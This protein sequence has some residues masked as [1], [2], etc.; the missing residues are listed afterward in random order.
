[1]LQI[2]P[3]GILCLILT[4]TLVSIPVVPSQAATTTVY[5]VVLD[6]SAQPQEVGDLERLPVLAGKTVVVVRESDHG[7]PVY[8]L[9]ASPFASFA[10]ARRVMRALAKRYPD[11]RA[12]RIRIDTG[13]VRR[14]DL[15][16]RKVTPALLASWLEK[17]RQAMIDGDLKSADAYFSRIIELAAGTKTARQ[18]R[19]WLGVVA[20]RRGQG[21]RARKLYKDFLRRYPKG[22]D[23]DRVRQRLDTLVESRAAD[24]KP[25]PRSRPRQAPARLLGSLSQFVTRDVT[26]VDGQNVGAISMLITDVDLSGRMDRGRYEVR[27]RLDLNHRRIFEGTTQDRD[28]L[29]L[30]DLYLDIQDRRWQSSLTIGRQRHSSGGILGRFDG[31]LLG[32]QYNADWHLNAFAGRPADIN[33][34]S[35]SDR[36]LYGVSADGG[37][38]ADRW[39]V[40]AYLMRQTA[41][42]MVD[43]EAL[44]GELRYVHGRQSHLLLLDYDLAY[45]TLNDA[46]IDAHWFRRDGTTLN[47]SLAYRAA[48]LL[49]T[50]N[51][52]IG[53]GVSSIAG[54]LQNYTEDEVR[55]LARDRTARLSSFSLSASRPWRKRWQLSADF[56]M[57]RVSETP[58][59]GGVAAVPSNGNEY[60]YSLQA[61]G[62]ELFRRRDI[63]T[64]ILRYNA[65]AA[66]DILGLD[67][68][69]RFPVDD[70]LRLEPRLGIDY[71]RGSSTTVDSLSLRPNLRADYAWRRHI[72][73]DAEL[74]L[75]W[76]DE[77]GSGGGSS[78]DLA[79]ELGYR[80]D[81]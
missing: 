63:T 3:I 15:Q 77:L 79:F 26:Y 4:L 1:M 20:E 17:G 8:V 41:D 10:E 38:F 64:F 33:D 65:L 67:I 47:A 71:R 61:T 9:K 48:P 81:F 12:D 44:G 80:I 74:G 23:S 70:R 43:R 37:T 30:N 42:G 27:G 22:D 21:R 52:L 14:S 76:T 73:F 49:V 75:V 40:N 58:A 35:D 60:L 19:E 31:V 6:R 39:D 29:R 54:L 78:L 62:S 7:R 2:R 28:R 56:N 18:A 59:S 69:S 53:Q 51:A 11:A 46:L 66:V 16:A 50:E 25:L 32:H 36:W 34:S 24:R 57:S 45:R 13:T 68:N 5:E 72:A 55:Q